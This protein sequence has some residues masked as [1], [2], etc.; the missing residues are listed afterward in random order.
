MDLFCLHCKAD[1]GHGDG[2]AGNGQVRG[3][4]CSY[5]E[6]AAATKGPGMPLLVGLCC[7]CSQ[8]L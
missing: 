2:G 6:G 4:D 3:G 7:L 5:P 8:S 1:K